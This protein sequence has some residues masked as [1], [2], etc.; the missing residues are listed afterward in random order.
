MSKTLSW[1]NRHFNFFRNVHILKSVNNKPFKFTQTI[2]QTAGNS[3]LEFL[4]SE[5]K[6]RLKSTSE[7]AD[8]LTNRSMTLFSFGIAALTTS[9]GYI[10]THF[11]FRANTVVLVPI[12]I[13]LWVICSILKKNIVPNEYFAIGADPNSITVDGMFTNLQ[14][15]SPKFFLLVHL[16]E[17]YD[18]RIV[19]NRAENEG[20]AKNIEHAMNWIYGIPVV[21]ICGYLL[22]LLFVKLFC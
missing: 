3:D 10:A 2:L 8:N 17:A 11:E 6:D 13:M 18:E 1:I 12:S 21:A 20:K 16:I 5:A 19:M 7:I 14:N 9:I 4:L 15:K 22:F